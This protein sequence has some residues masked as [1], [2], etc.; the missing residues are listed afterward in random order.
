MPCDKPAAGR[1]QGCFCSQRSFS[2]LIDPP[3]ELLAKSLVSFSIIFNL[4]LYVLRES[5]VLKLQ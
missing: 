5:N 3:A 4:F 1:L 2:S